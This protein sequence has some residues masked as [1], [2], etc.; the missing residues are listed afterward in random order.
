MHTSGY[1]WN[2]WFPFCCYNS[3]ISRFWSLAVG[4]WPFSR[5][6]VK[7]E[8]RH[9][10]WVG[11]KGYYDL[12]V[13]VFMYLYDKCHCMGRCVVSFTTRHRWNQAKA[14]FC[15]AIWHGSHSKEI[16]KLQSNQRKTKEMGT[17]WVCCVLPFDLFPP[18][19]ISIGGTEASEFFMMAFHATLL[20][21][22]LPLRRFTCI[23]YHLRVSIDYYPCITWCSSCLALFGF[24]IYS[25]I[26]IN[27]AVLFGT[28]TVLRTNPLTLDIAVSKKSMPFQFNRFY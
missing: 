26:S 15:I 22:P 7:G 12:Y 11:R 1:L 27:S 20:Y 9:W 13:L 17:N 24:L 10:C 19:W 23:M 5:K 2:F 8:V 3:I 28:Y 6:R 21:R 16:W 18:Q 4:I 25:C 14:T